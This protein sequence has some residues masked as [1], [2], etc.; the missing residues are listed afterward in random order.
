LLLAAA[1]GAAMGC[2][3]DSTPGTGAGSG[4]S[5]GSGGNG[6]DSGGVGGGGKTDTTFDCSLRTDVD[7][8]VANMS[9]KGKNNLI[10]FQL[11][12]SDPGPPI[13]GD[14]DF[15]MKIT[16]ADGTPVTQGL[17]VRVWMPEHNHDS[18]IPPTVVYDE[19]TGTYEV[20]PVSTKIMGGV[21]RV[22]L[23]VARPDDKDIDIDAADFNFCIR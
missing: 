5:G 4:G 11:I 13:K 23:R 7:A 18:L 9:K 22:S 3:G 20:N 1:L 8:Y 21:W 17:T 12:Q 6:E 19:M 16:N 15:E 10:T 14:N 2:A